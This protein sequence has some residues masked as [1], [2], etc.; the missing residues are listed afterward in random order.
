MMINWGKEGDIPAEEIEV[1]MDFSTSLK[2]K[3]SE[4]DDAE[5]S[6]TLCDG[7]IRDSPHR[8]PTGA[9]TAPGAREH[10]GAGTNRM[11]LTAV[12]L[13]PGSGT[14]EPGMEAGVPQ[15]RG[16]QPGGRGERRRWNIP[17][18]ERRGGG[19]RKNELR[20]GPGRQSEEPRHTSGEVWH[21]QHE[22]KNC[23]SSY[24]FK[25]KAARLEQPFTPHQSRGRSREDVEEEE[26]E[27]LRLG[28]EEGRFALQPGLSLSEAKVDITVE[29][30][31]SG[32]G[33]PFLVG[34]QAG[35]VDEAGNCMEPNEGASPGAPDQPIISPTPDLDLA[36]HSQQTSSRATRGGV[37]QHHL[38]AVERNDIVSAGGSSL[39]ST[40]GAA[41]DAPQVQL[42]PPSAPQPNG[43]VMDDSLYVTPKVFSTLSQH[44][45]EPASS[46]TANAVGTLGTV[47]TPSST[48]S[49]S[50][51]EYACT[52]LEHSSFSDT[53]VA[54]EGVEWG[55]DD[56]F[57][58]EEV[59]AAMDVST[60][61]KRKEKEGDD[62]EETGFESN[63]SRDLCAQDDR[64][65]F[66]AVTGEDAFTPVIK[67]KT[68]K[69][70]RKLD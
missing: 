66:Q 2:R 16:A 4:Y 33:A 10:P 68:K 43:T 31:T 18:Q 64:R 1:A 61:L 21:T 27:L 6:G 14:A 59:E 41:L 36:V 23:T 37:A 22:F 47:S 55:K 63:D 24:A 34:K 49:C 38:S 56:I 39:I 40:T 69:R 60:S 30:V 52:A 53:A 20:G 29:Q 44:S 28:L 62:T 35:A 11:S 57:V 19:R 25:I 32:K 7:P 46:G 15:T 65:N 42:V 51:I 9:D 17:P 58:E 8:T 12:T 54:D 48:D 70:N 45:L 5:A 13:S 26:E 3:E 67:R 50:E